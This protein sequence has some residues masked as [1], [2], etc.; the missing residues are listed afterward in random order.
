MDEEISVASSTQPS[1]SEEESEVENELTFDCD[2]TISRMSFE[3]RIL[4]RKR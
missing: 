2:D 4:S 3:G 1:Q